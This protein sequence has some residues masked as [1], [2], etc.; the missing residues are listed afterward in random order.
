MQKQAASICRA[1]PVTTPP[2]CSP[3]ARAALAVRNRISNCFPQFVVAGSRSLSFFVPCPQCPLICSSFAR[4]QPL[5][6]AAAASAR[7][8][9]SVGQ[10]VAS[11][12]CRVACRPKCRL[13]SAARL[14]C[15]CPEGVPSCE[16]APLRRGPGFWPR[17]SARC[18]PHPASPT[19]PAVRSAT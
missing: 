12:R 8:V 3:S 13:A 9:S 6:L 17:P 1:S 7:Q 14:T 5:C 10:K 16:H 2:L 11:D 19:V 4:R 18:L 15:G